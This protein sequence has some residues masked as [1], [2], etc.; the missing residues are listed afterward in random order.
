M[1]RTNES[2]RLYAASR[3][4][5]S[6]A[7]GKLNGVVRS[8]RVSIN[9]FLGSVQHN[10]AYRLTDEFPFHVM[11][12]LAQNLASRGVVYI[13]CALA[14]PDGGTQFHRRQSEHT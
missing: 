1:V 9:H 2:W 10:L 8:K 12:K 7:T 13:A 11:L 4:S 6:E 3:Q 14:T 5:Q